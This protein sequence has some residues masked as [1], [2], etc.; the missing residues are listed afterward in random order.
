M[1]YNTSKKNKKAVN[2]IYYLFEIINSG[3][4]CFYS[5]F[6]AVFFAGLFFAG[7]FFAG[8]ALGPNLI[9]A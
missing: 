2:I 1:I 5:Y 8:A 3:F 9:A 4:L 6:L 7:L